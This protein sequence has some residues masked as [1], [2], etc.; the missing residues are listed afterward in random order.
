M[1]AERRGTVSS[2]TK[3]VETLP[4]A[5]PDERDGPSQASPV[6]SLIRAVKA[7]KAE[8]IRPRKLRVRV[9]TWNV[10]AITG[11]EL[12]LGDWF[13]AEAS[14]T[15]TAEALKERS[16]SASG[17]ELKDLTNRAQAE[18]DKQ[19]DSEDGLQE[20]DIYVLGLQEVVD[21]NSPAEALRPFVDSGPSSRWKEAVQKAIPEYNL[22]SSQ[23]MVGLL[24]LIYASPSVAP[25]VTSVNSCSVGTGLMGYMGNKGAVCTRIVVGGTTRI[26]FVNC[27]LAAGNDDASLSRRNWDAGQIISRMT[28]LP[29]REEDE[30][31]DEIES[32][33]ASGDQMV[34]LGDEEFAFWFGDL[35]YRLEDIPGEDLRRLLHLHV[36]GKHGQTEEPFVPQLQKVSDLPRSSS[37]LPMPELFET[38]SDAEGDL[39][40]DSG[41]DTSMT[42]GYQDLETDL[43]PASDPASLETTLA[44]LLPHD[45][46]H[47]QQMKEQAFQQGWREGRISFL[48][49]YK[50][51]IGEAGVFDTSKKQRAP[52]W[53]DRILYRTKADWEA[54]ERKRLEEETKKKRDE[55]L[56]QLGL[57]L[58]KRQQ[59]QKKEAGTK[60]DV[61]FDYDFE[62][63]DVVSTHDQ[64]DKD[65]HN[66]FDYDEFEDNEDDMFDDTSLGKSTTAQLID[67]RS[68]QN[69]VSSDHKPLVA[70]FILSI[71]SV[72][73]ELKNSISREVAREL[74]KVENESRPS[75]TVVVDPVLPS[76]ADSRSSNS[77]NGKGETQAEECRSGNEQDVIRFGELYY[78]TPKTR[79]MTIANTGGVDATF[80]FF[81]PSSP[82]G[83]DAE[84]PFW[85][86]IR[87]DAEARKIAQSPAVYSLPPG[88]ATT[89]TLT[90]EINDVDMLRTLNMSKEPC[91]E[92]EYVI[93]LRLKGGRDHF[94][95]LSGIWMR[96]GVPLEKPTISHQ[97]ML[98]HESE[99]QSNSSSV[100]GLTSRQLPEATDETS[101]SGCSSDS[102]SESEEDPESKEQHDEN[103]DLAQG[104]D[105][106]ADEEDRDQKGEE[107]ITTVTGRQK[108]DIRRIATNSLRERLSA[109]LP[110]LKAANEELQGKE[111]DKDMRVEIDEDDQEEGEKNRGQ[112]IEMNLGLGVLKQQ[113]DD[114]TSSSGSDDSSSDESDG[115]D[116]SESEQ[117]K[118][119]MRKLM[120]AK[121]KDTSKPSIEEL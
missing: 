8:Y 95:P 36:Q 64:T 47:R 48:P 43:D 34:K 112:Y 59:Q 28:F 107:S 99:I 41:V 24:L 32:P 5:F 13:V 110:A 76:A 111:D 44:S 39:E 93:I 53:C 89:V 56:K 52:S 72:D 65:V 116:S 114:E 108:P 96:T 1:S 19:Q 11:T 29:V 77:N 61:I 35:N 68:F 102:D 109:F 90:I 100:K 73:L 20:V 14:R 38:N 42:A 9:G 4:G 30:I 26:V 92:I 79:S 6:F 83:Q 58:D 37:D 81:D 66:K 104:E 78:G 31:A 82:P 49:T 21:V 45:Q 69:I 98:S 7:R 71:N 17:G 25:L 46:L 84:S 121:S 103:M 70:D 113:G 62:S 88:A 91:P 63:D 57:G 80:R 40:D 106:S 33:N 86:E 85:L 119:V 10:A 74:D 54:F 94:L 16:N 117:K 50:Y 120:G 27:H 23:Q 22:V 18:G 105:V 67:Y 51:D 115:S 15:N 2:A 101:S 3:Q 55:A 60:E 118:D 75:I 97:G 87:P 12:D